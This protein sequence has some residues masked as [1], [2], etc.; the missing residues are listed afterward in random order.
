MKMIARAAAV[1][2]VCVFAGNALAA[3]TVDL[4]AAK[5]NSLYATKKAECKREANAKHFGIHFVKKDRWVKECIAGKK[6]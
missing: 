2:F 1:T 4:S 3:Q 5:K 6:M